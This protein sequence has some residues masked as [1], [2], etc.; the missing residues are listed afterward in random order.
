ML[1]IEEVIERL[2]KS[3]GK[4][5]IGG[6]DSSND[7]VVEI[8]TIEEHSPIYT[9]NVCSIYEFVLILT[10]LAKS[11][12]DSSEISKYIDLV[13]V[14]SIINPAELAFIL[15]KEKKVTATLIR[16][17]HGKGTGEMVSLDKLIVNP[18]WIERIEDYYSSKR[19]LMYDELYKYL[20]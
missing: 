3:E 4:E 14:N 7:T 15:I 18:E 5:F 19:D 10:T 8:N 16:N 1:G 20:I 12:N 11:L 2:S 6:N 13:N 17:Y 9:R